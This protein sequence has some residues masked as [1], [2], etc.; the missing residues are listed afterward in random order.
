MS[1]NLCGGCVAC[2]QVHQIWSDGVISHAG[3]LCPHAVD[4][5]CGIYG[6]HPR[7]CRRYRCHW[8]R[9]DD[10]QPEHRPDVLGVVMAEKLVMAE[11]DRREIH[12]MR[13]WEYRSG[14]LESKTVRKLVRDYQAHSGLRVTWFRQMLG[15]KINDTVHVPLGALTAAEEQ[16]LRVEVCAPLTL[17]TYETV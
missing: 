2:C 6:N 1:D 9:Q 4:D 12:L 10:R 14:A 3:N 16:R 15:G 11:S 7:E 17:V 5:G 8:L 13:F